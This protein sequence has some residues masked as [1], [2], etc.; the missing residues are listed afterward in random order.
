MFGVFSLNRNRFFYYKSIK[1]YTFGWVAF[2]LL[3]TLSNQC[4]AEKP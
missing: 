4:L 3:T 1:Y 2:E